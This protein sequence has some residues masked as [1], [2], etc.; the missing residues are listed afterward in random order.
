MNRMMQEL[1]EMANDLDLKQTKAYINQLKVEQ[2]SAK[3]IIM[4]RKRENA[5]QGT[6]A[7]TLNVALSTYQKWEQDRTHPSG[8]A[9][10]LL[11]LV[12][13]NGLSAIS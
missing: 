7:A 11:N 5:T 3:Q 4:L 6:M 8:P 9:L 1:E 12:Q 13:K 10:K 2:M